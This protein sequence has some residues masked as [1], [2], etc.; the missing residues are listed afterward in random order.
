VLERL[1]DALQ[2]RRA[3]GQE[4]ENETGWLPREIATE[5][6]KRLTEVSNYAH[7]QA[8]GSYQKELRARLFELHT[9]SHEQHEVNHLPTGEDTEVSFEFQKTQTEEEEVDT[10]RSELMSRSGSEFTTDHDAGDERESIE[11]AKG[12]EK[13]T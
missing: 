8:R 4:S 7:Q 12:K 1:I 3:D 9:S 5:Y 10:S 13:R 6:L 11:G 2:G